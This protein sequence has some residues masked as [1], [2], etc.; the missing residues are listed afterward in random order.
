MRAD[1]ITGASLIEPRLLSSLSAWNEHIPAAGWLIEAI[2]PDRFVELGTHSGVSYFAFCE[3]VLRLGLTTECY[4]VDHWHGDEH[5]GFYGEEIYRSVK[6]LNGHYESSSR[7]LRK[8]FDEA[9]QEFDGESIDLLHI[10]GLHTYEAVKHDFET[11][12]PKMTRRGVVLFHDTNERKADFGVYK[13]FAELAASHPSFEFTHGHGLGVVAVGDEIPPGLQPL[14]N[15]E[16]SSDMVLFVR[17]AYRLLGGRFAVRLEAD[18]L[19]GEAAG[20]A[21]ERKRLNEDVSARNREIAALK[22][23]VE[24]DRVRLNRAIQTRDEELTRVK[25]ARSSELQRMSRISREVESLHGELERRER[26]I[27][28]LGQ[29]IAQSSR[30]NAD[31]NRDLVSSQKRIEALETST[32]WRITKPLRVVADA[33]KRVVRR[34]RPP[35]ARH[36]RGISPPR[37]ERLHASFDEGLDHATREGLRDHLKGNIELVAT[38]VSVILPTYNRASVL[39]DAISSVVEQTHERWE[40]LVIDDGSADNTKDVVDEFNDDRIRYVRTDRQ[41]VGGARNTGL[42]MARGDVIAYLDSDNQWD[43]EFLQLMVAGLD[44]DQ[45]EVAYAAVRMVEGE[46]TAGFRGD[47]FDYATCLKA[48]YVDINALCHRRSTIDEGLTFEPKIRRTNDWDLI[49]SLGYGRDVSYFPFVGVTYSHEA[50]EDRISVVEPFVFRHIV[51]ARHRA[52][53]ESGS[54]LESFDE[55]LTRLQLSIAIRIAAPTD[56]RNL[57]GDHHF[58]TGLAQAF[59]RLGHKVRVYYRETKVEPLHHDVVIVLRGLDYFDPV[60]QAVNVL[61][62]ISHPDLVSHE[63]MRGYDVVFVASESYQRM[64]A[65]TLDSGATCLR[66]ATDRARFYPHPVSN[67]DSTLLFVGNSRNV[68][69]PSVRMAIDAGLP[70]SIHGSGWEGIAP[71]QAIK[72]DYLANEFATDAYAKAAAVLNDH[73]ESM[74]DFGYISNRVYDALASGA[75][76]ISDYFPELEREYGHVVSLYRDK[77]GFVAAA[78][79]ALARSPDV[80]G[81][82]VAAQTVT[83]HSFDIRATAILGQIR[84]FLGKEQ[85]RET[86]A[87]RHAGTKKNAS[88][89]RS[90]RVGVV[91]Q[92]PGGRRWTSSTYIRLL[93]PLTSDLE[94]PNPDITV[95]SPNEIFE[96]GAIERLDCLVVSRTAIQSATEAERLAEQVERAGVQLVVDTDDAF[97]LMDASHEE[98]DVYAPRMEAFDTVA[99]AAGEIWCSTE[100][101]R[102]VFEQ[103]FGSKSFTIANSIDPRLWR[104]YRDRER[105]LA[106]PDLR[107]LIYF[108]TATHGADLAAIMPALDELAA[109]H[110]GAFRLSVIGVSRELPERKWIRR[111]IP[112]EPTTYPDFARWMRDRSADFDIGIAPLSETRFN[113]FK[114]DIKLLEYTAMGLPAVVSDLPPYE[115]GVWAARCSTSQ[116]WRNALGQLITDPV[117]VEDR[118]QVVESYEQ[119]VWQ[120]RRASGTGEL[121][122][123]RIQ[124]LTTD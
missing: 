100:A 14:V 115:N 120:T 32:F 97:H 54:P 105:P 117:A 13:L 91:P 96:P 4:A 51:E 2:R 78:E 24:N 121:L 84:H 92:M 111:V 67:H 22:S 68:N 10:D 45:V 23:Q 48:N 76:V 119:Q 42:T 114:S 99:E 66:Q 16:P 56:K 94:G 61:W 18:R 29:S 86:N 44:R 57:W 81:R 33:G 80:E 41:G 83:E 49:L 118:R 113:Q 1:F 6:E 7:L 46:Q 9:A 75:H 82:E 30:R 36:E 89:Q 108:G 102:D 55:V 85:P 59:E 122:M 20:L 3:A 31:V 35:Q 15:M 60:P 37:I 38:L 5:S 50:E 72:S 74:K 39:P 26:R 88:R 70:L 47:Y 21:D 17:E 28:Q 104:R 123:K 124:L 98:S 101:L 40:L 95:I 34:L 69:R 43:R 62:S 53:F 112:P 73:W 87:P 19:S 63:E 77:D 64:L 52:R 106:D 27:R 65:H 116:E 79:A 71:K 93:L 90:V 12:L 11:W 110:P 107:E 8:A 109:E 58:A 103:R 25:E